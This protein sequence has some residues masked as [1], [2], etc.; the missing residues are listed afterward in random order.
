MDADV[1]PDFRFE[2]PHPIRVQKG[3]LA[4]GDT[5]AQGNSVT[6]LVAAPGISTL[7]A[8][9][10]IT[11]TTADLDVVR[12]LA[13]GKTDANDQPT[14]VNL[15]DGTADILSASADGCAVFEVT[16]TNTGAGPDVTIDYLDL[17]PVF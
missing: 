13:D 8:R 17:F 16:L 14:T 1:D 2:D 3:G 6:I 11:G 15:A 9:A 12:K 7:H 5:I 10:R 4:P